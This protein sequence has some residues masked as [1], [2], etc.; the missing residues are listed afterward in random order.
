M[1]AS[2]SS[3]SCSSS[4]SSASSSHDH[5]ISRAM[6]RSLSGWSAYFSSNRPYFF[7]QRIAFAEKLLIPH[8]VPFLRL[9]VLGDR[10]SKRRFLFSDAAV[11]LGNFFF[12]I[13]P[14]WLGDLQTII[15]AFDHHA[16]AVFAEP[17]EIYPIR[18]VFGWRLAASGDCQ[19][20]FN[21]NVEHA[22]FACSR[23]ITSGATLLRSGRF[24]RH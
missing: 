10:N 20:F 2:K 22:H 17:L 12:G 6:I 19:R 21:G 8:F 16:A 14:C 7:G 4:R 5:P 18:H 13:T 1:F 9:A 23:D 11:A 3:A 24:R 15:C